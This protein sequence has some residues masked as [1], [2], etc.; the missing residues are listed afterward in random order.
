MIGDDP[1][2]NDPADTWIGNSEDS[3]FFMKLSLRWATVARELQ[4]V[5]H[6][7]RRENQTDL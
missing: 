6:M 2:R 1:E 5:C 7:V 4:S 3:E